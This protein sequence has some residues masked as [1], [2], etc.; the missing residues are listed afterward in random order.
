MTRRELLRFLYI[1]EGSA[2]ELECEVLL[3]GDLGYLEPEALANLEASIIVG[4]RMLGALI[5]RVQ[6]MTSVRLHR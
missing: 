5:R 1:A 6:R 4:K 2:C 3:S